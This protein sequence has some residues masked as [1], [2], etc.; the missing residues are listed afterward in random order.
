MAERSEYPWIEVGAEVVEITNGSY[1]RPAKITSAGK[2]YVKV[3]GAS[4]EVRYDLAPIGAMP[5]V[6][7]AGHDRWNVN[8]VRLA[9]PDDLQ[10]R[11]IDQAAVAG[12][13]FSEA[14]SGFEAF[15]R[16]RSELTPGALRDVAA[17]LEAAAVEYERLAQLKEG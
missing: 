10:V 5:L 11:R 17:L 1:Y 15:G 16:G 13:L 14:R 6:R 3:A 7:R 4:G 9:A 2:R 8:T 12:R